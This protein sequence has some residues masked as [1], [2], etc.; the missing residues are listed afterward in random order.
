MVHQHSSASNI[1]QTIDAVSAANLSHLYLYN[2]SGTATSIAMSTVSVF[3]QR[4][5]IEKPCVQIRSICPF[6][7]TLPWASGRPFG[8]FHFYPLFHKSL[9]FVFLIH[10]LLIDHTCKKVE[11]VEKVPRHHFQ[12]PP[13]EKWGHS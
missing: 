10:V 3:I 13:L 7:Y 1:V 5:F 2:S 6:F 8:S 12:F 4:S 9:H 11:E